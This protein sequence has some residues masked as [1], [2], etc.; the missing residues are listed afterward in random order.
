MT[1]STINQNALIFHIFCCGAKIRRIRQA[2]GHP[3][4]VAPI[5]D[6]FGI[7]PV[8]R[9]IPSPTRREN[10]IVFLFCSLNDI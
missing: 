2:R 8:I 5:R 3:K 10:K 7:K 6:L 9:V 4:Y 1:K